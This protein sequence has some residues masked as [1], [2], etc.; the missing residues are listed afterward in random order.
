MLIAH[1]LVAAWVALVMV[2]P[3]MED[4]PR[5]ETYLYRARDVEPAALESDDRVA[6]THDA[7]AWSFQPADAAATTALLFFP[8]GG[9]EP[10]AY[11]PLARTVAARGFAVHVVNLPARLVAPEA[12]RRESIARGRAVLDAHPEVGR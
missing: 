9:V 8:G 11:A 12:H 3:A 6:V 7:R 1:P 5:A 10:T 2:G 4:P